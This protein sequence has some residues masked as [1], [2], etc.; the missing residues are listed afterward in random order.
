MFDSHSHEQPTTVFALPA[1]S[2]DLSARM[3]LIMNGHSSCITAHIVSFCMRNAI[4]L[5]K[6]PPHTF[7]SLQPLD[8]GVFALLKRALAC[9]TDATLRHD[10]GRLPGVQQVGMYTL[11]GKQP[12]RATIHS[13]DGEVQV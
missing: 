6:I 10:T 13:A 5:L 11:A 1:K 3:L 2:D 8:I 12:S 9:E 7:C 4:D